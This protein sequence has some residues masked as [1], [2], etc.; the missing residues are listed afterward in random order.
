MKQRILVDL[1]G[2]VVDT[3]GY[4]V[5]LGYFDHPP[6]R[7]DFTGCC[8]KFSADALFSCTHVFRYA[9]PIPFAIEGVRSL[10]EHFDVR[11]VSTPWQ[12]NHA[13]AQ[14][15]YE[16]VDEH[17]DDPTL[18]V[19]AHD[20]TLIPAAALIDDKPGLVGPWQHIVY[21]QAW[22]GSRVPTWL[23]GLADVVIGSF[24]L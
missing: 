7:W 14:A 23:E 13:S 4:A 21:P 24:A 8:T 18:L 3:M 11:F 10:M 12:T 20:K 22:N 16:W 5:H 15:K 6:C 2:T 9:P 17:F 1:D 19:L